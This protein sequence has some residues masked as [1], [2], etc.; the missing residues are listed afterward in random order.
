MRL[1]PRWTSLSWLL[2][3][4]ALVMATIAYVPP[5]VTTWKRLIQSPPIVAKGWSWEWTGPHTFDTISTEV[6]YTNSCP[7][8]TLSRY[9]L[10]N[11]GTTAPLE[12]RFLT[13]PLVGQTR[14]PR[15]RIDL[16]PLRHGGSRVRLTIPDWVDPKDVQLYV[17]TQQVADNEPCADGWTG[18]ADVVRLKLTPP[19]AKLADRDAER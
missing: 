14:A 7:I 9:V 13:G 2:L 18:L 12:A 4:G 6:E 3:G 1:G 8:V 19:P 11:D 5:F 10:L 16:A 17:F 15:S